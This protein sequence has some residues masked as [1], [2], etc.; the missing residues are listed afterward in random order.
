[1]CFHLLIMLTC[2]LDFP[3]L[4]LASGGTS[5][6][7]TGVAGQVHCWGKLKVNGDNQM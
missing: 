6:F 3:L 1:M 2:F 4:Q 7:C 5:S